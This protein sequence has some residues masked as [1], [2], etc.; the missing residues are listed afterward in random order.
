M[1][2]TTLLLLA[3]LLL[4]PSAA[5]RADDERD[6]SD[7]R[8]RA[9]MAG[10][11]HELHEMAMRS[12]KKVPEMEMSGDIDKDFAKMMAH[13]HRTGIEMARLEAEHGKNEELRELAKKIVDSQKEELAVLE[14][15][16]EG[17]R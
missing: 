2:Q 5:L 1:R 14:K 6:H 9:G 15:H 13:H 17:S 8:A 16:T 4:V 11:S 12:S 10:A 3:C 7:M